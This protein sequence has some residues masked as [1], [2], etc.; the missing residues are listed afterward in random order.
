VAVRTG[1]YTGEHCNLNV[2]AVDLWI[3]PGGDTI[4]ALV[5]ATNTS[6]G[7]AVGKGDSGGPVHV[8]FVNGVTFAMGT[9][10][11]ASSVVAC[12]AGSPSNKCGSSVYYVD[13]AGSLDYYQA[14]IATGAGSVWPTYSPPS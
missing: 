2:D 4:G 10:T 11:A 7:V 9:M 6:G 13:I 1:S 12:P 14:T 8:P 3:S 5:R